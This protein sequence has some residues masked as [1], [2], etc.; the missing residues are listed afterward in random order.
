MYQKQHVK[1]QIR[2]WL[3]LNETDKPRYAEKLEQYC[4]V[5]VAIDEGPSRGR[6][7]FAKKDIE[8]LTVIGPYAGILRRSDKELQEA[9]SQ[10]G[11]VPTL[12]YLFGTCSSER[13]IDALHHGNVTS[14]VNTGS[15][16][17]YKPWAENNIIAINVG[18]NLIFYIAKEKIDKGQE[19]LL[20]YGP[21]YNPYQYIKQ[22]K[23]NT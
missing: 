16:P 5:A 21:I 9:I 1:D 15:M 13:S 23:E 22:E 17:G 6:S 8:A 19:L 20:D 4:E 10:N 11:S 7:V 12:T 14:L 3:H 2:Q 18:K